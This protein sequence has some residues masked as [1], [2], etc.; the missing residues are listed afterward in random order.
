MQANALYYGDCLDWMSR[1]DDRTVDLIYLDP[2]FN[3][4]TN[5]NVLYGPAAGG[6]QFQ[7]FTDTWTWD[8]DAAE[9]CA[10]FE[11]AIARPAHRAI[12]GL[13]RMLGNSGM[14]AYLSYM[15]ERLEHCHRLL[16]PTGSLYLHCDPTASHSLKLVLDAIFGVEN[17]RNEVVWCYR[18]MPSRA[19]KFQSKHD[20]IFFYARSEVA[21]FHVLKTSPALGSLRTFESGRTRGYNANN[22]KKM[23]TVFDWEKY[24]KAVER[25]IIPPDLKPVAFRGGGSLR[26]VIGGKISRYSEG[27]EIGNGLATQRRSH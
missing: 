2:P 21:T 15:A 3:S 8:S 25:K 1:W 23:V 9:R 11:R 10:A 26:C 14:M 5:Y 27:L 20:V 4:N 22:S 12:T 17:F 18:G 16:K 6:A 7:A 13:W 24:R 19:K